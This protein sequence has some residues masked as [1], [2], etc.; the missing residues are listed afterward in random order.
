MTTI[1]IKKAPK[2]YKCKGAILVK[3]KMYEDY[4]NV[5]FKK[6]PSMKANYRAFRNFQSKGDEIF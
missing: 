5:E 1:T 6:N 4:L 3:V 2:Q